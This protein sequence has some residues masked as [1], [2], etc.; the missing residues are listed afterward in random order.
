MM[1]RHTVKLE[2]IKA[3]ILVQQR[4]P[5]AVADIELPKDL[6]FGQVLIKVHYSCICGAQ[7]NE[8]DGTKGPDKNLPHLLGHEGSGTV[9]ETGPGVTTVK[10]EDHVVLHWRKSDGLQS[11]TPSYTCG[12]KRINAGWVTTFQTYAVVSENR[13]T[14]IP[15]DF[16]LKLATLFGCS[17][18]TALGVVNN[19]ANVK[20]GQ[21][22]VVFGVGGVGLNIIQA[23]AMVSAYPIIAI[24]LED[25]KLK[26]AKHF[27]AS[28]C[29]NSRKIKDIKK[30][31]REFV[32]DDDADV[33]IDTTGNASV[34]EKSYEL[35]AP[36]GKTI[37]VGVPNHNEKVSIHTLPLHFHKVLTGSYGGDAQPHIDIPRY[38][39]L[40]RAGKLKLDGIIT[41]EFNLDDINKAIQLVRKR[42]AGR[43]I[44]SME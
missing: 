44:L 40:Y 31:V 43:V 22:V 24:D 15:H 19:D 30:T 26:K 20:I 29:L 37:L 23:A 42:V 18:T 38:V 27:G 2:K 10:R 21:S 12:E 28:F 11:Q 33:V 9:I 41:H 1:R 25:S 5:L 36:W 17:V 14:V 13:I 32:G 3:A 35:T 16:D 39:R 34:I 7:I 4:T 6:L 8:I